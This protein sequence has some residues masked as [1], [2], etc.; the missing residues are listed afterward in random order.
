MYGSITTDAITGDGFI[1]LTFSNTATGFARSWSVMRT[2]SGARRWQW[3]ATGPKGSERGY[4]HSRA[5]AEVRAKRAY[6]ELA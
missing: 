5:V 3:S 4:A 2:P 6:E 1:P